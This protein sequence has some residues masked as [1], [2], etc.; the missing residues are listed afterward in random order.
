MLKTVAH[1]ENESETIL[2]DHA[3]PEQVTIWALQVRLSCELLH[4]SEETQRR[5]KHSFGNCVVPSLWAC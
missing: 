4:P 2:R 5:M 1:Q 3:M